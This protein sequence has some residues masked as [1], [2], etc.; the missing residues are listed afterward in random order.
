MLEH[1]SLERYI[2]DVLLLD[3]PIIALTAEIGIDTRSAVLE[4]GA[5]RMITKPA[6]A[7]D[8]IRILDE[9]IYLDF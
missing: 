9:F 7:D 8:I 2:R 3:L 4:A 1:I 5:N 6:S